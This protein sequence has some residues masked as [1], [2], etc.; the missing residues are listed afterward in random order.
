MVFANY[1]HFRVDKI[2]LERMQVDKYGKECIRVG[3]FFR[4]LKFRGALKGVG[5]GP[6]PPPRCS[7]RPRYLLV[8]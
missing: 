6:R 2:E 1:Q 7:I 4:P 5:V 8:M 3:A